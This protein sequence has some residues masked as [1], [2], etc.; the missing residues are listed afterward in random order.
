MSDEVRHV[1]TGLLL[2]RSG[3]LMRCAVPDNGPWGGTDLG[4]WN[5]RFGRMKA[6]YGRRGVNPK[7]WSE[8]SDEVKNSLDTD[9]LHECEELVRLG[10]ER[11]AVRLAYCRKLASVYQ[12][13]GCGHPAK[14]VSNC[15][16]RMCPSCCKGNFDALFRRFA[17][18]DK[19]IPA[20]IRSLAG[21]TWHV[22]D[23]SFRH[24][25]DFPSQKELRAMVVVIR[26]TVERAVHEACSEW[27]DAGS[28]CRPRFNGGGTPMMSRDGWPIGSAPDGSARELVGWEVVHFPEHEV[29]D[30]TAR[31]RGKWGAKKTIPERWKPRFGYELIRVTE[32]GF[33]NV[34]AHFHCAY[35]GPPLDYWKSGRARR[36]VCG[37]RLV[38]IFKVESKIAL[39]VESYTVFFERAR[40][41]FRS[42]LAHA[43]KYTKKIPSST[44]EGLAQLELVLE[45]TRR[46][47]LLG[48][49]YGVPLKPKPNDP[50]CSSCGAVMGRVDGLGLVPLYEIED[51]PDVEIR[52]AWMGDELCELSVDEFLGEE[53]ARAP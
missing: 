12:C 19:M 28:R 27:F 24:D 53:A 45:G 29:A 7:G 15:K 10:L 26:R 36:L 6:K 3:D 47:A 2:A 23:F 48:A 11:K 38:E 13:S 52:S 16:N 30:N 32:F 42:V 49:H 1:L 21:W 46:V 43:L 22:L 8:V 20:S 50:K 25:G 34:N 35:F 14:K 44:P 31:K 41:G 18:V 39:G 51:L 17:E 40:R 4:Y 33:D 5:F 37:G 9:V